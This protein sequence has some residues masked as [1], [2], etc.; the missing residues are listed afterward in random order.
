MSTVA[1]CE[2]SIRLTLL[3]EVGATLSVKGFGDSAALHEGGVTRR[4]VRVPVKEG[5][6]SPQGGAWQ[7]C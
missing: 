4:E 3:R 2:H 1:E 7:P 5:V 6:L